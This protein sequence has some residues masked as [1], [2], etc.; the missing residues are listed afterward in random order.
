ML[1]RMDSSSR[2]LCIE[3]ARPTFHFCSPLLSFPSKSIRPPRPS[4]HTHNKTNSSKQRGIIVPKISAPIA[5]RCSIQGLTCNLSG[6]KSTAPV[7]RS[8]LG[9]SL[10]RPNIVIISQRHPSWVYLEKSPLRWPPLLELHPATVSTLATWAKRFFCIFRLIVICTPVYF[11]A[12]YWHTSRLTRGVIF[13]FRVVVS[14]TRLQA[15]DGCR[16]FGERC[17]CS[18]IPPPKKTLLIKAGLQIVNQ[19]HFLF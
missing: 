10:L 16:V 5:P 9:R 19:V 12:S 14:S 8:H 18:T 17:T 11:L 7:D 6:G 1:L 3:T 4:T 15:S 13:K 2:H